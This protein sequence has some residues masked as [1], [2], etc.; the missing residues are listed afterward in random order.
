MGQIRK[1][2]EDIDVES[3]DMSIDVL[4]EKLETLKNIGST[5][6]NCIDNNDGSFTLEGMYFTEETA[7]TRKRLEQVRM[8]YVK[9]GSQP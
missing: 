9:R 8:K 6:I 3:R 2:T 7:E 1:Y 4:I 5:H